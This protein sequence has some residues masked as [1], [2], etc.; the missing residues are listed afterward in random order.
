[1]DMYE[2][3]ASLEKMTPAELRLSWRKAFGTPGP[4]A[5]GSALMFR[6][7]AAHYQENEL[8]CSLTKSL[9]YC[10]PVQL[11]SVGPKRCALG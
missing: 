11:C 10:V 8:G 1:M 2:K 9:S 6:A 5:F 7:L 3:I 4:P